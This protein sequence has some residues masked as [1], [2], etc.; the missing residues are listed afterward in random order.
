MIKN[1]DWESKAPLVIAHRGASAYAPENTMAAFK[2]AVEIG[3]DAIELDVKLTKDRVVVVIHDDRVDR[4]T[5]G[6]GWVKYLSY[7]EIKNL[8]AGSSYSDIFSG[9]LI[10]TLDQVLRGVGENILMNIELTN[11]SDARDDLPEKV[12]EMVE[13]MDMTRRVLL[14]SFNP[15][16]LYKVRKRNREIKSA[17]LVH[18]REPLLIRYL[19]ELLVPH[20]YFHPNESLLRGRLPRGHRKINVWTV[21]EKARIRELLRMG[22][23]GIITDVPDVAMD[24]RTEYLEGT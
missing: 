24:V 23:A 6:S 16:A 5:D 8:D 13:S 17:L 12:L 15:I 4:T 9:E 19:L 3:A 20:D 14:S 10:P 1:V 22:I 11:Y 18:G 2:R 7:E 21:N